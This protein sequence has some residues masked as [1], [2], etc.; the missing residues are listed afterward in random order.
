MLALSLRSLGLCVKQF[1]NGSEGG[2]FFYSASY[3]FGNL[4]NRLHKGAD[5]VP[6]C[7]VARVQGVGF[8]GI[9]H[10]LW[11]IKYGHA[12]NPLLAGDESFLSENT[13]CPQRYLK[14]D[15]IRVHCCEW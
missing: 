15:P 4:D 8:V 5:L 10:I 7:L 14:P 3:D 13:L 2:R 9:R 12:V 1:A 6:Q 11:P